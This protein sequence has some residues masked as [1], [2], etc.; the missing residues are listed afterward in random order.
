VGETACTGLHGANRLA[1]NSLLEALV[2]AD[3]A[4]RQAPGPW[5]KRQGTVP[6]HSGL[7]RRG[8][9]RQRRADHGRPQLGRD[10]PPHVELRGHRALG[11]APGTGPAP[12][13]H[14]PE[15]NQRV[16]LEFQG[17]TD[18]IELRNIATVA[19]LII[20]CAAHRKESRGLHYNI[21]YP[22]RDDRRWQIVG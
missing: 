4:A 11:Q 13:R 20:K 22:Q 9:H 14:H 21:G 7:G 6:R 17:L 18:L 10:P 5:R 3:A 16:L 12:H 8:H 15:G 19:E 1:S 2:Y